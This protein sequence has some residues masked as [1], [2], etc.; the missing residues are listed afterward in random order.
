MKH[1]EAVPMNKKLWT[2]G[3]SIGVLLILIGAVAVIHRFIFGLGAVSSLSDSF[4]WGIWIFFDVASGIPLAAGGFTMGALV[5]VF[6][7]GKYHPLIKPAIL[8]TMVGYAMAGSSIVVDIGRPWQMYTIFT[9]PQG[10]SAMFE[11]AMCVTA[12]LT[13]L[14]I[15][16]IPTLTEQWRKNERGFLK[17]ISDIIEPLLNKVMIVF[18]L[19][20]ITI[21]CLHQSSLGTLLTIIPYKLHGLWYTPLLPLN[22]L[23]SAMAVGFPMVVFESMVSARAFNRKHEM[24]LL[25]TL[26]KVTTY[27]LAIYLV[28]RIGDLAIHGK[29]FGQDF[30]TVLLLIELGL[31]AAGLIMLFSESVRNNVRLLFTASVFVILGLLMNRFMTFMGAYQAR[32]G[33][34][35]FPHIEEVA[36]TAMIT[37][38][39][40]VSYKIV[41]NYFPLLEKE[42]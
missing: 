18:I 24:N 7:K 37:S 27:I 25:S 12:Y 9:S 5:Y 20:G 35:Y 17:S 33:D 28:I 4:P 40:F 32:P 31:W 14:V 30:Y 13:V 11:V 3:F 42:H 21:S 38:I 29:G 15:E 19:L 1:E 34:V 36:I 8:T 16:F 39:I 22:F 26:T 23:V 41:A 2:K 6:N 10:N